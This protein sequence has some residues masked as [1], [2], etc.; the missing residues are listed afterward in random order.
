[1]VISNAAEIPDVFLPRRRMKEQTNVRSWSLD[2]G[3]CRLEE[4][5]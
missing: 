3:E 4:P 2:H 1:M 5:P